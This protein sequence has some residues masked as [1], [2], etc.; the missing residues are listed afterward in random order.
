MTPMAEVIGV[1][2]AIRGYIDNHVPAVIVSRQ[3]SNG[4]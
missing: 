1:I 4:N 2:R 3:L